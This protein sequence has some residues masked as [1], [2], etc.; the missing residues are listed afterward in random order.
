MSPSPSTEV[1][2]YDDEFDHHTGHIHASPSAHFYFVW[3]LAE[4]L[5]HS[6]IIQG[7]EACSGIITLKKVSGFWLSLLICWCMHCFRQW[8]D[9][10]VIPLR[11]PSHDSEDSVIGK[12]IVFCVTMWFFFW[13]PCSGLFFQHHFIFKGTIYGRLVLVWWWCGR[14]RCHPLLSKWVLKE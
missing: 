14:G 8:S 10:F 7:Q 5:W 2:W 6:H 9:Q 11:P 1:C 12:D 3:Y 4:G 13:V